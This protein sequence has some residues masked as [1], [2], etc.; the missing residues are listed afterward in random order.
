MMDQVS[1][2]PT[3]AS[4]MVE[5]PVI[6]SVERLE[7]SISPAG[8]Q[9]PLRLMISE[10][11]AFRSLTGELVPFLSLPVMAPATAPSSMV[12]VVT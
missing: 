12:E 4:M 7:K 10:P 3:A 5:T 6:S 2:G 9:K 1:S 11:L 8:I